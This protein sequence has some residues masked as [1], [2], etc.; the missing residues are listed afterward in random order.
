VSAFAKLQKP[1]ELVLSTEE[2]AKAF[3]DLDDDA[4]AQFFVHVAADMAKWG[5]GKGAMQIFYI[6]KHLQECEC[7]TEEARDWVKDLA[8]CARRPT[9]TPEGD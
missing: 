2:I 4:Q 6:G 7:S 3:C 8:E 1:M 5:G 9:E